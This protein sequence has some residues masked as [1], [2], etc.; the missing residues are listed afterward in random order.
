MELSKVSLDRSNK[1]LCYLW[2]QRWNFQF[3][4]QVFSISTVY[5]L[6]T[7][8]LFLFSY[9]S[10]KQRIDS[11]NWKKYGLNQKDHSPYA[12]V[13]HFVINLLGESTENVQ[14]ISI[15][16]AL[17]SHFFEKI[18]VSQ[19]WNIT[20]ILHC[21][22]KLHNA[23]HITI[24]VSGHFVLCHFNRCNFNRCNFNRCNFNRSHFQP[25]TLSTACHF[26]RMQF[27]PPQIQPLQLY[28]NQ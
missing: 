6:Q 18:F 12:Q 5:Q 24:M 4:C 16:V 8:L 3:F 13:N 11:E 17:K 23:M 25:F 27:R 9:W 28:S 14:F 19:K 26:N 1:L 21:L 22:I 15:S 10:Q 2:S 7:K 20:E